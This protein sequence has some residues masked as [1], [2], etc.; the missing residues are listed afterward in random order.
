LSWAET[1]KLFWRLKGL[2]AL[3]PKDQRQ[4]YESIGGHPRALEYLD[5]LLNGGKALFPEVQAKLRKRLTADGITD[6]SRWCADTIG[7]LDAALAKTVMFAAADVL[8]DQLLAQLA[9]DPLARRLLFGASVYRVPV[10]ELGLVW[11]VGDPV[12]QAPDPERAARLQAAIKRLN[13]ARKKD[14]NASLT[15]AISSESELEQFH[16]DW[17]AEHEPP[18]SAPTGFA[19]AKRRLLDLSLL[20]PVRFADTNEEMFSVH[21]WTADALEK[22]ASTEERSAANQ[23]AAAWWRWRVANKPQSRKRDIEDLLEARHHLHGLGDLEAVYSISST[24]ILQLETWGAWEWEERLIRETLNWMPAGSQQAAALLHHLGV[25][26]QDKGDYDAA[27]DW[28]RQSLAINEQ[29]GNRAGMANSYHQLGIVTQQRGDYDAA[30]DWYRQSLA[31]AEQLGNRAS[32]AG[33]Y[34][35]L[36]TVAQDKG[37]YDAALD[38]YR[39]SLAISE[40]LGNRAGMALTLG[41]IGILY[42]EMK[43]VTEA[44]PFNLQ[45]LALWL[46]MRSPEL[47]I[48]LH[49][50]SRQRQELGSDKFLAIVAQH[51][52]A[53]G[54]AQISALL[55]EFAREA[56]EA[57][58]LRSEPPPV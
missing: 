22:R 31:I 52:D 17:A 23:S 21:R 49:W 18:M 35:N 16:R 58:P 14:P 27:L 43:Q 13:E 10:D 45:S 42:T 29:R 26:A 3:S 7:G 6:T 54:T 9:E 34:H 33:S 56:G 55:D 41:Q 30:L 48:G 11:P 53:E 37:D 50:L 15:D 20:A 4:A 28:Y 57:G 1:R 24:V 46:Q 5:A 19:S 36:G 44:V 2:K 32:M 40:Q 12:E 25:V 47:H 8:L 38:W 39:Q 51:H